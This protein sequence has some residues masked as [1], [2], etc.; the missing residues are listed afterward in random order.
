MGRS[1]GDIQMTI[2]YIDLELR[3]GLCLTV[4]CNSK[5]SCYQGKVMNWQS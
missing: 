1:A 5:C 3:V 4:A 2:G